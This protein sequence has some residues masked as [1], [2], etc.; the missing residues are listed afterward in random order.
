MQTIDLGRH[1]WV[2][3]DNL[4][5]MHGIPNESIDLV[6]T[7][8][9]YNLGKSYEVRLDLDDYVQQQTELIKAVAEKIKST[10]Y[11]CWQT[12]YTIDDGALIPLDSLFYPVFTGLG[13]KLKNRV[14]W[15]FGSGMH[16]R[17]RFSG[18]HETVMI[19]TRNPEASYFDL[20]SVR[21]P[22][23]YPGKTHYRGEKKGLPSG[24]PLG[25]NPGDVWDIPNVKAHHV[26]K[27][28]HD[29]QFPIALVQR[30]IRAYSPPSGSVLDP[31]AGVGSTACAAELEGR[32][33]ISCEL[34]EGFSQTGVERLTRAIEGNLSYRPL[35]QPI[36][37]PDPN[38]KVAK[39]PDL[40]VQAARGLED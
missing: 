13:F 12:G 6:V 14:I 34:S 7:S 29:C 21:V 33:S 25:K 31:Y 26:E 27:T 36:R 40:F 10:G 1:K 11:F 32:S 23:K 17:R 30:L 24:N 20:D 28:G 4:L 15:T 18:R 38:S 37:Q 39:V 19:F 2:I 16:A 3:G 5:A 9:P 22:Q 35:G 8:P